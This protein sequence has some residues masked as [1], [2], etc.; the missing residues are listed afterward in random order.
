MRNYTDSRA[1]APLYSVEF[2]RWIR[3]A[4]IALFSLFII[5]PA[6][7]LFA[8]WQQNI[9]GSGRV[10]AFTPLDRPQAVQAPVSG[11]VIDVFVGE[12]EAVVKGDPLLNLVDIDPKK[13][14][15]LEAKLEATRNDLQYT[16]QNIS[17]YKTQMTILGN[18]RDLAVR[19][20][21]AKVEIAEEQLRSA[22]QRLRA[23]QAERD[24]AKE[25]ETRVARL[26]PEFV[27]EIKLLEATALR[28]RTEAAVASTKADVE[29]AKASRRNAIAELGEEREIANAKL[30]EARAKMQEAASKAAEIRAKIADLEGELRA[31]QTQMVTAPRD[32]R[33]FRLRVN[34][35]SS[36]VKQGQ[37][38]LQIVP[39]AHQ[40]AVELWVRGVDAP[41][42]Q[43]G[44]K[45]RLQ[46]EGWPAIQFVGWP[47]VA[48]GTFGGIVSLVDPTD[49]GH[50]RFRLL[51]VPDPDDQPWPG[52]QW[53]RQGVRA[54]GWVLLNEVALW[55][56]L[57]RQLNGFPPVI[58]L[59]EPDS[60]NF[61][62][63]K[64]Q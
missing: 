2:S 33:V 47:S 23:A 36:I 8:P 7:A 56:E 55:Y 30:E 62:S 42:I 20:F 24:F 45:V 46:F 31:Q 17:T 48:V 4:G 3:P 41:L 35:E 40:P 6:I 18:V 28:K 44:R 32:G 57:W 1:L 9:S 59:S 19:A 51:I 16:T 26:S 29:A 37:V 52:E 10:A 5:A 14:T 13:I 38:L 58:A 49:S 15:R 60:K 54:K 27:E 50:G 39:V 61:D 63:A 21:T 25:Q 11:R 12:A 34:T 43:P 64:T 53:L 22:R